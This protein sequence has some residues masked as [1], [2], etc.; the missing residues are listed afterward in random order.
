[1]ATLIMFG[2][3]NQETNG[4]H[5]VIS[6]WPGRDLELGAV[7]TFEAESSPGRSPGIGGSPEARFNSLRAQLGCTCSATSG[8]WVVGK[9]VVGQ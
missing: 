9:L 2:W 3:G 6:A 8:G 5:P 1:M 7:V 4:S